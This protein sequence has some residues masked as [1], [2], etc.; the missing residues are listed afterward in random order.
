MNYGK[1]V[2][3]NVFCDRAVE[4]Q[5]HYMMMRLRQYLVR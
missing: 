1:C 2:V 4:E 3:E 5:I